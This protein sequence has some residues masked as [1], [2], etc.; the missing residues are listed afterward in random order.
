MTP[1][2][3]AIIPTRGRVQG[4]FETMTSMYETASHPRR[5]EFVLKVDSDDHESVS[6]FVNLAQTRLVVTPRGAGYMDMPRFVGEACDKA[7]GQW[8]FLIDDDSWLQGE[9]WDDQLAAIKPDKCCAQCEFY[10]LGQSKY[11]SGS[12]GP[13]GLFVPTDVA[14]EIHRGIGAADEA[15]LGLTVGRGWPKHLLKGITY[16]HN[17]RPR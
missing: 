9:G 3:S 11:G 15:L 8:C 6:K 2:V 16:C 4:V 1:L 13:N 7:T 17:G 5:I 14:R 10:N 12:C